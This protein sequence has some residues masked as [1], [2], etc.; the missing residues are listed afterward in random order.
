MSVA[1]PGSLVP[2]YSFG[3]PFRVALGQAYRRLTG[4]YLVHQIFSVAIS[5]SPHV[6]FNLVLLL[7][8]MFLRYCTYDLGIF[9]ANRK[10]KCMRNQS[11][12]KGEG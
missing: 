9:H 6:C 3:Y 12:T 10:T 4:G 1:I 7:I 11:R 8:S 5:A 2:L